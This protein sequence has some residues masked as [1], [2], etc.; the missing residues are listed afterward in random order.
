MAVPSAR[1]RY[2]SSPISEQSALAHGSQSP[3]RSERG[4]GS[5]EFDEQAEPSVRTMLAGRETRT[6]CHMAVRLLVPPAE[7][8]LLAGGR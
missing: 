5:A 8:K 1:K 2:P 7:Y 4:V 6:V 3:I